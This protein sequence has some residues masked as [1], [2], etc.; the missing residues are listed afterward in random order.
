MGG[1]NDLLQ[2]RVRPHSVSHTRSFPLATPRHHDHLRPPS[3]LFKPAFRD[4][5]LE[6]EDEVQRIAVFETNQKVALLAHHD[7]SI[8]R[9]RETQRKAREELTVRQSEAMERLEERLLAQELDQV[10]AQDEERANGETALKHMSAYCCS[11]GDDG[12]EVTAKDLRKLKWQQHRQDQ[13]EHTHRAAINVLRGLQE[14]TIKQRERKHENEM[15]ELAE[16]QVK[17]VDEKRR[18]FEG[19]IRKFEKMMEQRRRRAAER[20]E[21]KVRLRAIEEGFEEKDLELPQLQ[22]LA[23]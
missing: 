10:K 21:K 9:L 13:L 17:E 15:G 19:E 18:E 1:K 7:A 22:R 20:W 16:A 2:I 6:Y 23:V 3:T 12:R 4:L 11:S 14:K 5:R 8:A